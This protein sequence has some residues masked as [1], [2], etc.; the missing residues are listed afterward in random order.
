MENSAEVK[1]KLQQLC[2]TFSGIAKECL[3]SLFQ[4]TWEIR[5]PWTI[6]DRL[7][8]TFD[9]IFSLGNANDSFQAIMAV[10]V[11]EQTIKSLIPGLDNDEELIDLFGEVGNIFCGMLMDEEEFTNYF[12]ILTQSVPMHAM[13]QTFFPRVTGIHG[14]LFKGDDWLYFGYAIRHFAINM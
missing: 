2:P 1:G 6:V 13:S 12:G 5:E 8:G 7:Q 14:K 9:H 3:Q 11:S 4:D 10:G